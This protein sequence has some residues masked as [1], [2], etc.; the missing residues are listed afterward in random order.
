[1]PAEPIE[2]NIDLN[3]PGTC[4]ENVTNVCVGFATDDVGLTEQQKDIDRHWPKLG[5]DSKSIGY[6][7]TLC[8]ESHKAEDINGGSIQ[9]PNGPEE[10]MH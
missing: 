4:S 8:D 3:T 9:K 5:S 7:H 10:P 6:K 1:M 2:S